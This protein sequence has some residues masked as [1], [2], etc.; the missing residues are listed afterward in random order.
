MVHVRQSRFHSGVEWLNPV[1]CGGL[2]PNLRRR[3]WITWHFGAVLIHA[4]LDYE[5]GH[6]DEGVAQ[7]SETRS[8]AQSKQGLIIYCVNSAPRPIPKPV[9]K[10]LPTRPQ[11]SRQPHTCPAKLFIN[12]EGRCSLKDYESAGV[13]SARLP[14]FK[15]VFTADKMHAEL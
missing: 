14:A 11:I 12:R 5:S 4:K 15:I 1:P 3:L 7:G 2:A 9:P 10:P 6:V 13:S 8:T